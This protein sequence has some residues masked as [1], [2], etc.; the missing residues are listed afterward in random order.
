MHPSFRTTSGGAWNC[1]LGKLGQRLS[2]GA[3]GGA[4][5]LAALV[6]PSWSWSDESPGVREQIAAGEEL[7]LREWTIGDHRSVAGD[8]LGPMYN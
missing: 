6:T 4:V 2:W 7:F 5:L 8:G 3:I 1:R